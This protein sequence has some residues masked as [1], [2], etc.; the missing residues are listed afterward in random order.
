MRILVINPNTLA[1]VTDL[2][3]THVRQV[4]GNRAEVVPVTG[5]FGARYIASR[6]AA[7]IAGHAALDAL[8]EHVTGCDAVYLACF[9]DPGLAALRE[10]SPVP[11]V[12]MAE[13]SCGKAAASGR[14]GIVTGGAA[15]A[16]MLTEFVGSLGLGERFTGVRT[17]APTGDRI[18]NDPDAALADLAAACRR[19]AEEDDAGVVILG[20]AALAGLAARIQADV[21]VPVLCSVAVGTEAAIAAASSGDRQPPALALDSIGLG[22]ALTRRLSG[23]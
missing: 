2:V 5:R 16:P 11:V 9:G 17:I 1:S 13:A 15:W 6:A 22:P 19:C 8:A 14:F 12:G 23:D 18:A 20:G 7:C 10:I 21:P 3:A 4:A